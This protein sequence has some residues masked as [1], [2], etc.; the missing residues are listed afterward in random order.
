MAK[1][2]R[3]TTEFKAEVVFEALSGH[4]SQ[5]YAT[6]IASN[7]LPIQIDTVNITDL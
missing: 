2:R 6:R 4:S 3:F 5:A 1:R 7:M